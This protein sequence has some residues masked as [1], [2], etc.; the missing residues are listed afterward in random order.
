[1]A[2]NLLKGFAFS[3]NMQKNSQNPAQSSKSQISIISQARGQNSTKEICRNITQVPEFRQL[4]S[5]RVHVLELLFRSSC[6]QQLLIKEFIPLLGKKPH[7]ISALLTRFGTGR[8]DVII[9]WLLQL[10]RWY[11]CIWSATFDSYGGFGFWFLESFGKFWKVDIPQ[12]LLEKLFQIE[13]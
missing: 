8:P 11:I 10:F 4:I 13:I 12:I 1:M 5:K 6:S 7:N 2:S 9:I 3:K